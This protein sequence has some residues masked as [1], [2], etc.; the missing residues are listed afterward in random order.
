MLIEKRTYKTQLFKDG[1]VPHIEG[2]KILKSAFKDGKKIRHANKFWACRGKLVFRVENGVLYGFMGEEP[3]VLT[4]AVL[5]LVLLTF[6]L[7][8][9]LLTRF[10]SD[11]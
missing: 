8:P 4:F 7:L 9:L 10:V 3:L 11:W 2:L 5:P 1:V 6:V